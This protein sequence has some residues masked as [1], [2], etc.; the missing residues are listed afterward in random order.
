MTLTNKFS[1]PPGEC[2][3]NMSDANVSFLTTVPELLPK[4]EKVAKQ[5][6]SIKA[7]N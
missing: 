6:K 4:M 3:Y 1:F 2:V 5:V 7:S